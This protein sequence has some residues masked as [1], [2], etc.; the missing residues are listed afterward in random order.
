[1]T[2]LGRFAGDG[3][4][5]I[6]ALPSILRL[7]P[8]TQPIGVTRSMCRMFVERFDE[9]GCS[10]HSGAGA[11]LWVIVEYCERNR[12]PYRIEKHII[13]GMR[14]IAGYYVKKEVTP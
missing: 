4:N 2:D 11:V 12:I 3:R 8:E 5:R 1:M 7:I 13:E 9:S 10:I 6:E 14:G